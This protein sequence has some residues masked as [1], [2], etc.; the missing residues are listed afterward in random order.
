MCFPADLPIAT[1]T[2][3]SREDSHFYTLFILKLEFIKH[4]FFSLLFSLV[5]FHQLILHMC[6]E[7]KHVKDEKALW[8]FD[9]KGI[10][11]ISEFDTKMQMH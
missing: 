4:L 2:L 3:I 10:E 5:V 9:T 1:K 7:D 11:G 6:M 8:I